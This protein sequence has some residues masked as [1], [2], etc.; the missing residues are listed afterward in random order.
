MSCLAGYEIP[1]AMKGRINHE[2]MEIENRY[3]EYCRQLVAGLCS[4]SD[5]FVNKTT[6][7][8]GVLLSV[9]GVSKMDMPRVIGRE[10]STIQAI[11]LLVR[12]AAFLE[13][14]RV[15]VKVEEPAG[16]QYHQSQVA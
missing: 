9:A 8:K 12:N 6:D 16:S 1:S 15:S 10:G 2:H 7:E 11:R 3:V 13:N 14:A 4:A 5:P